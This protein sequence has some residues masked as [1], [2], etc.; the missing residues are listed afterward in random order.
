MIFFRYVEGVL[1]IINIIEGHRDIE[2]HFGRTDR[3]R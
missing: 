3:E 1:E 2:T